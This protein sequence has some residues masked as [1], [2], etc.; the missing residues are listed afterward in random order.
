MESKSR[1]DQETIERLK[2][3]NTSLKKDGAKSYK[4]IAAFRGDNDDHPS[5]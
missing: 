1:L 5:V 3:E 4:F 2:K